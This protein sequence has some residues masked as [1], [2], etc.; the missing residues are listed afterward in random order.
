MLNGS[1]MHIDASHV[2]YY[3]LTLANCG[4]G[5]A[6]EVRVLVHLTRWP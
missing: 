2:M 4:V 6:S 3:E 5:V 1:G